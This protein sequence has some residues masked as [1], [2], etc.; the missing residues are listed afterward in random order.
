[1]DIEEQIKEIAKEELKAQLDE[2]E[3]RFKEQLEKGIG[4]L[5]EQLAALSSRTEKLEK[6]LHDKMSLVV[7]LRKYTLDQLMSEY[8]RLKGT[9]RPEREETVENAEI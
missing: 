6:E 3:G 4:D 8:N 2:I 5:G 1:M 9:L 7:K